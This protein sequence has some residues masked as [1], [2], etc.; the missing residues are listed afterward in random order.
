LKG[1]AGVARYGWLFRDAA[2][3]FGLLALLAMLAMNLNNRPEILQSGPFYVIDGDTL[4]HEGK[5]LRLKGID[6]PEYRQECERD[7]GDWP[8]GE[9]ARALLGKLL[10]QGALECRA[11]GEDR[12]GRLLATCFAGGTDV[13][14]EMVRRGMAVAFGA[15]AAEE[16]EARQAGAGLWAGHFER[17]QDFRR[18]EQAANAQ[19]ADPLAAIG[20]LL[21]GFVA[22]LQ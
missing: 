13:G 3:A 5:R 4:S 11:R 14:G 8:C 10:Q 17:P 2:V 7:G 15:Y 1:G 9:D 16:A 19:G 6:A 12:Y 18:D 22:G 20:R 21:G